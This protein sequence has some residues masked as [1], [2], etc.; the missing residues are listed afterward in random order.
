MA[1]ETTSRD[2]D[3]VALGHPGNDHYGGLE[4]FANPG[5]ADVELVTTS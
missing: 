4:S 2:T 3:F 5:V 1:V